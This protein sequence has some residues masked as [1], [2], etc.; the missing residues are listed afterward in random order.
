MWDG[1]LLELIYSF[2]NGLHEY[3]FGTELS[4][5]HTYFQVRTTAYK[6]PFE[7]FIHEKIYRLHLNIKF[8][9]KTFKFKHL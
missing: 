9:H 5:M 7:R 6:I 1:L 4:K 3:W 2:S 8:Q